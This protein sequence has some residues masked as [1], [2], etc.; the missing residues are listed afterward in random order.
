MEGVGGEGFGEAPAF[1]V[2]NVPGF[3]AGSF[4]GEGFLA[5]AGAGGGEAGGGE[6]VEVG[7]FLE[8]GR[9]VLSAD[10]VLRVVIHG[11]AV[12]VIKAGLVAVDGKEAV[13]FAGEAGGGNGGNGGADGTGSEER[14]GGVSHQV[15]VGGV[16]CDVVGE[17]EVHADEIATEFGFAVA[18][19]DAGRFL[20]AGG[21]EV[22][23]GVG[24]DDDFGD[25][26][27]GE[28]SSKNPIKERDAGEGPEIFT[29]D[30]GAVGFDGQE[31][32]EAHGRRR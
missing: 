3:E 2:V 22:G 29:G 1:G 9:Q 24:I 30:A 7:V 8:K 28:K 19:A 18:Q 12:G 31:G 21:G 17:N 16:I 20:E 11:G 6:E 27:K 26:R 23:A 15:K 4:E 25:F 32:D 10:E 5:D 13:G 14:V